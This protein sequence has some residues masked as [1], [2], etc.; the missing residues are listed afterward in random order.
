MRRLFA[1]ILLLA[2][3]GSARAQDRICLPPAEPIVPI[4]DATF[5][6]YADLIAEEFERYFSEV[7]PYIACLDAVRQHTFA[8]AREISEQH[9]A[10][11]DRADSLG[12]TEDAAPY[13]E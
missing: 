1:L 2:A 9:R 10:F 5:S 8:R 11:W 6:E 13:V 3:C 7:S 12:L 4:D